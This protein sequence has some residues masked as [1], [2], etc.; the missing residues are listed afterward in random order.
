MASDRAAGRSMA[1]CSSSPAVRSGAAARRAPP[2]RATA[3][4]PAGT[5][6]VAVAAVALVRG[7]DEHRRS[8][9]AQAKLSR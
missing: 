9:S 6:S 5:R 7:D 4:M 8:L 1:S 3:S 2:I